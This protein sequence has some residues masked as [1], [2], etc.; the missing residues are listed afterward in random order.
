[1]DKPRQM[2]FALFVV[3]L[4]FMWGSKDLIGYY[5]HGMTQKQRRGWFLFFVGFC[6]LVL[7]WVFGYPAIFKQD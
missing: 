3:L 2:L 1:M 6:G 7:F 5:W 4:A